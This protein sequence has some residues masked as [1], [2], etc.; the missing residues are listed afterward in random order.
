MRYGCIVHGMWSPVKFNTR[1][2]TP[3]TRT[4][5]KRHTTGEGCSSTQVGGDTFSGAPCCTAAFAVVCSRCVVL[6]VWSCCCCCCSSTSR[7]KFATVGLEFDTAGCRCGSSHAC[8][9][10]EAPTCTHRRI[11]VA[12]LFADG[13]DGLSKGRQLSLL[14]AMENSTTNT[15]AAMCVH[16]HTSSSG[17]T[18]TAIGIP[19]AA[20]DGE[21]VVVGE[22]LL[23]LV[24][25][26][27]VSSAALWFIAVGGSGGGEVTMLE[28]GGCAGS[29]GCWGALDL[30]PPRRKT[31]LR[32]LR[33]PVFFLE[34]AIA[35]AGA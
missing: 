27:L 21:V 34:P 19:E 11:R 5:K 7:V 10:H 17:T 8:T 31:P 1:H 32:D 2:S 33:T 4:S 6:W 16:T 28:A 22:A 14:S 15:H 20:D 25:V 9:H 23:A 24:G 12:N 26:G 3:G 18:T 35:R 30:L 29:E 13:G